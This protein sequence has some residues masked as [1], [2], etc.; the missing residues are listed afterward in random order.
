MP[1]ACHTQNQC[2][3]HYGKA[4]TLVALV[5]LTHWNPAGGFQR[6][7]MFQGSVPG[8]ELGNQTTHHY[9]TQRFS[10]STAV[11]NKNE[12]TEKTNITKHTC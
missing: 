1:A 6:S 12:Q 11:R 3:E 10:T 5:E 2:I 4:F 7:R 9:Q 8:F